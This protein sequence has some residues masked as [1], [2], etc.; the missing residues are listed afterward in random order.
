MDLETDKEEQN[1]KESVPSHFLKIAY[2]K[3]IASPSFF[4]FSTGKTERSE[5]YNLSNRFLIK[6][7]LKYSI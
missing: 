4:S 5:F 2:R 7:I 6:N 1:E 3:K